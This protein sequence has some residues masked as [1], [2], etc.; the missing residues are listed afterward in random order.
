MAEVSGSDSTLE[1]D[2]INQSFTVDALATY[3]IT[4]ELDNGTGDSS[5]QT[6]IAGSTL[7]AH[8]AP[9]KQNYIFAYWGILLPGTEDFYDSVEAGGTFTVE[10][11]YTLF[12]VYSMLYMDV[13][14]D[15]NGGTIE[16]QDAGESVTINIFDG[17]NTVQ[18]LSIKKNGYELMHW[19][20]ESTGTT[21]NVGDEILLSEDK[22]AMTLKAVWNPEMTGPMISNLIVRRSDASGTDTSDGKYAYVKFKWTGGKYLDGSTTF[23]VTS[24]SLTVYAS[25]GT[26][27][28]GSQTITQ[29]PTENTGAISAVIT[30]NHT[31]LDN[32]KH[33]VVV[34]VT[35]ASKYHNTATAVGYVS[36]SFFLLDFNAS[37]TAIGMGQEAAD[38]V[39]A[40]TY[41]NGIF[42][43]AM[44][45]TFNSSVIMNSSD[46]TINSLNVQLP[47]KDFVTFA[48]QS[49]LDI[50]YP[51]GTLVQTTSYVTDT[52]GPTTPSDLGLPGTWVEIDRKFVYTELQS[53]QIP[54]VWTENSS[55]WDGS[56]TFSARLQNYDISFKIDGS[57]A[58][59]TTNTNKTI[60][61]IDF[62]GTGLA[63]TAD[64]FTSM[65]GVGLAL[66]TDG[67][68]GYVISGSDGLVKIC[69]V[70]TLNG[71]STSLKAGTTIHIP[72]Q[73]MTI[74]DPLTEMVNADVV[75]TF[76][77]VS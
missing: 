49:I 68:F 3:T 5:S 33:K 2:S 13:T 27:I 77:R 6:A 24:I 59:A 65:R 34:T 76:R 70:A 66:S 56:S 39:D 9:T 62:S 64:P 42:E 20:D 69:A 17:I 29:S 55:V 15:P 63:T 75:S 36:R 28:N 74:K 51:I 58:S 21:Y 16:G 8:A 4:Y 26:T 52:E 30:G 72:W 32:E 37:G 53:T 46:V 22:T 45:T 44:A 50:A 10:D 35:T 40:T 38:N 11:N 31:D 43:C 41:P 25:D 47:G 60:G 23:P 19:L 61:T 48:G 73:Y 57:L 1:I 67:L 71:A 14:Y 54:E 7:T 12:A 18:D